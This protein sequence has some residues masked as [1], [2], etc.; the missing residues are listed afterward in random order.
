MKKISVLVRIWYIDKYSNGLVPVNLSF[1]N[2]LTRDCLSVITCETTGARK[3]GTSLVIGGFL[4]MIDDQ[5]LSR[6]HM[7]LQLQPYLF[8]DGVNQ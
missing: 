2:L 4:H 1:V 6:C 8:L 7:F 3:H 5:D